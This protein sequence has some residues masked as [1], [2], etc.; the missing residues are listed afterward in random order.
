[1]KI[2]GQADL[3]MPT[4]IRK[5]LTNKLDLPAPEGPMIAKRFPDSKYPDTEVRIRLPP[6]LLVLSNLET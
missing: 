3:L 2:F 6:M 5:E 1:M 4:K